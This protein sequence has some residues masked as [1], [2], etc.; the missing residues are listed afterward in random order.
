MTLLN[1]GKNSRMRMKVQG[2]FMQ[3]RFIE[4]HQVFAKKKVG[5]FS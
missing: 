1:D 5:Y 2:H 4:I 3:A